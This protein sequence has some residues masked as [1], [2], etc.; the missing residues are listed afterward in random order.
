M[1]RT[2]S[3]A[4]RMTEKRERDEEL[5][6]VKPKKRVKPPIPNAATHLVKI[7]VYKRY[8]P[9]LTKEQ[10]RQREIAKNTL[11]F[12]EALENIEVEED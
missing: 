2:P 9:Y 6:I 5:P 7:W 1:Q 3:E 11:I 8:P 10:V 12:G 4:G